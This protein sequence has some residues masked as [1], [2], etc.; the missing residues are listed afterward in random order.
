MADAGVDGIAVRGDQVAGDGREMRVQLVGGIDHARQFAFA[1]KRAQVDVAEMQQAQAI[2]IGGKPGNRHVDF[3]YVEIQPFDE[4][5]IG[6]DREG[7]RQRQVA[8][9]VEQAP[10]AGVELRM[11]P[12]S[13]RVQQGA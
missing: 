12:L 5:P 3:A 8:G 7:R 13:Q 9:G 6:H 4:R 11:G 10:A 2:E 1:Q